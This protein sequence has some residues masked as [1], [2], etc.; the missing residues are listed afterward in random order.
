MDIRLPE[1]EDVI[2]IAIEAEA[3]YDFSQELSA[4]VAA[5][6]PLAM[7]KVLDLINNSSI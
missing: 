1:D 6:V 5:G 7:E 2:I 3:V 4:A